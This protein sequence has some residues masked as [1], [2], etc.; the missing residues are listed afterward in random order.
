MVE[1]NGITPYWAHTHIFVEMEN[2]RSKKITT[3][4]S[5]NTVSLTIE[6]NFCEGI[7]LQIE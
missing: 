7:N 1:R 5:K 4:P 2:E 6:E 3:E